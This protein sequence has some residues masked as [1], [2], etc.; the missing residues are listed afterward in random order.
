MD[1]SILEGNPVG[2]IE[3]MMIAGYAIGAH[4]GYFYGR[5]EYPIAVERLQIAIK[6]LEQ[7]GLLGDN[8]FGSGFSFRV[9]IRLGAGAFVWGEETALINSIEGKRGMPRPRPPFPAIK[10]L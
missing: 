1:R 9:H 7:A 5:A 8:I 2:V 4:D 10:G 3:G 6:Q